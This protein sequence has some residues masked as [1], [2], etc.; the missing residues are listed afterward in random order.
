MTQFLIVLRHIFGFFLSLVTCRL[1]CN[2]LILVDISV[3][4]WTLHTLIRKGSRVFGGWFWFNK[5]YLKCTIENG[6]YRVNYNTFIL[7]VNVTEIG[8]HDS[9]VV[10]CTASPFCFMHNKLITFSHNTCAITK[11]K[12]KMLFCIPLF[13]LCQ[14]CL[15]CSAQMLEVALL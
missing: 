9:C 5:H 2:K 4:D 13:N 8:L 1:I 14:W 6:Q 3:A 11:D 12:M 7:N 15:K 10:E